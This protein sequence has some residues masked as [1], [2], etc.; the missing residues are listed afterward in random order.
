MN[1]AGEAAARAEAARLSI[2]ASYPTS[3]PDIA[4]QLDRLA[5]LAAQ[6]CETPVS[7]VSFVGADR[8]TFIGR[9]GSDLDGTPRDQSF[10]AHAMAQDDLLI[11]P[12]ATADNRFADNPLVTGEPAIRFYAGQPLFSAEGFPLGAFC[13]ID[14]KARDELSPDQRETLRTLA[15]AAMALLERW[16]QSEAADAAR[17]ATASEIHELEQRFEIL[18]DA[19]PQLVW[20]APANGLPD[21]FNRG[22]C[23]FTGALATASYGTGWMDFLHPED[24][25]IAAAAW[26]GAVGSGDAYEVEYRLR[27]GD[28]EHRWMIA[29]GLPIRDR[30]G[31]IV[32]WIGT[33]TDINEARV[34]AERQEVLSRELSHRIK[35]IFAVISGLITMTIRDRPEFRETGLVLQD[36]VLA[37]GRAHDFVR[38]HSER[39]RTQYAR[40]SLKGMLGSLFEAYQIGGE[41]RIL[42][43]G[44][45]IEI[46]DRSATALALM[47]HELATNAAKYGALAT[48]EGRIEIVLGRNGDAVTMNW[49]ETGGPPVPVTIVR[50]FGSGLIELSVTR[51][52]GG[53][54]DY[55]WRRE[56]LCVSASIPAAVMTREAGIQGF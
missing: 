3:R 6:V 13:V 14:T 38:P 17:A 42:I 5:R 34:A 22:W 55:D 27:R 7:L 16:R 52:L 40:S 51:Q 19:M 24:V 48:R 30:D 39:S 50:G 11:V 33:C 25:P 45:D 28:G 35:N 36:R 47:F 31:A 29:R 4:E 15:N 46:D 9:S 53:T 41:A 44:D 8:Q 10:C 32:R 23:D 43:L 21:Y 18:A 49:T 56:G 26:D 20:S 37:L 12:D 54:L 2:L 1:D